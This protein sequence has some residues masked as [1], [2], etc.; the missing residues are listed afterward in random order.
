MTTRGYKEEDF[1]QVAHMIDE[2]I[3][4]IQNGTETA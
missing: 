2:V 4:E 1:I 3:K